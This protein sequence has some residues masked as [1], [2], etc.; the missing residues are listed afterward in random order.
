MDIIK[1]FIFPFVAKSLNT[2]HLCRLNKQNVIHVFYHTASG[3]YLPHI[4]PL[5]NPKNTKEFI[6]DIDFL[7]KHFQP[8]GIQDVYLDAMQQQKIQKPSFHLSFD[9][10][11]REVHD[12]ILPILHDKGVPCTV[13]VN[14]HFV[15]NHDL[16][17]RYKTALIINELNQKQNSETALQ[18]I[19]DILGQ[20]YKTSTQTIL[21]LLQINYLNRHLLDEIASVLDID[22]QHFLKI[23]RPYLNVEELKTLQQKGFS[24]GAHSIDHPDFTLLPESEQIKQVEKSCDYVQKTFGESQRYFAFP[25]S[26]QGITDSFFQSIYNHTDLTFGITGINTQYNGRHISRIDMEKYGKNA[27]ECVNKAYLKTLIL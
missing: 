7:L 11:L 19:H 3:E 2:T 14:S 9:D 21:K 23:Q 1:Q 10:G 20:P 8:V 5:Y 22:F 24:I 16:F 26:D 12:I 18:T 17:F 13:F 25:F 15:N 4:H 27:K 6:Q